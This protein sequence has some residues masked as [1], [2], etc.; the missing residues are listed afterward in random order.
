MSLEAKKRSGRIS[1]KAG[2]ELRTQSLGTTE[3]GA[4][5]A[6]REVQG[7]WVTPLERRNNAWSAQAER[8]LTHLGRQIQLGMP[9]GTQV[10]NSA[11]PW[12]GPLPRSSSPKVSKEDL[13]QWGGWK[14]GIEKKEM[15]LSCITWRQTKSSL[16]NTQ[17]LQMTWVT[18]GDVSSPNRHLPIIQTAG[19]L[20][21]EI[22]TEPSKGPALLNPD[23]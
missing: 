17:S 1:P 7:P 13:S 5:S 8:T 22:S 23:A 14:I 12:W 4:R 16:G 11:S 21:F 19:T 10:R 3:H 9:G 6:A 15:K 18:L 20:N 2:R